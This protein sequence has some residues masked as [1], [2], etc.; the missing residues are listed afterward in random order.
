MILLAAAL[1]GCSSSTSP[2]PTN[3]AGTWTLVTT[4]MF[5]GGNTCVL[6]GQVQITQNGHNLGG[7]LPGNGVIVNCNNGEG[8]SMAQSAGTNLVSGTINGKA[9]SFNL[10]NGAVIASGMFTAVGTMSG[11]SIA[12]SYPASDIAVSGGTWTATLNP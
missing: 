4:N 2:N 10:A 6:T 12:V 11:N 8:S 9:V 1:A 5:G 7:N 3:I